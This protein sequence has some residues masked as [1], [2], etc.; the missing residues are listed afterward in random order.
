VVCVSHLNKGGGSEALMRVTGSLAFVAAARAAYVVAKDREAGNRRLF[1]PL[2]NN[3]GNDRTGLAFTVQEAQ[4]ASPV[5]PI[6][7]ARVVWDAEA[8]TVTAD[9]AMANS[10]APEERTAAEEAETWLRALLTEEG[11]KVDRRDVMKAAHAMGFKD[12]TVHRARENLGLAVVQSGFGKDKR[13]FWNW[14]ESLNRANEPQSCQ[15]Q[16][17]G[18]NGD[19]GTIGAP[20]TS[21]RT[22]SPRAEE[23]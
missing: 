4:V 15:P 1:L 6:E 9:E 13:S 22:G 14:P 21:S 18:M 12:R 16:S 17:G 19:L 2:K 23:F 20:A 8:I 5:G 10:V 11:G 3:V 7:T